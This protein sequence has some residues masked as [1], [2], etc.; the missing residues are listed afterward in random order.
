MDGD[1][2]T[3]P[4]RTTSPDMTL[5]GVP[6][7]WSDLNQAWVP[8]WPCPTSCDDDCEA[9]CHEGHVVT[10]KRDHEYESCLPPAQEGNR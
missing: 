2:V 6:L 4:G 8:T 1:L 5:N 9:R 10:W 7:R 3:S